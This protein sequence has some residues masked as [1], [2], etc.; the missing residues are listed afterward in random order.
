MD[1]KTDLPNLP[2]RLGSPDMDLRSDPRSDP[3]MLAA[4]APLGLDV[5]P[6]DPGV[7]SETPIEALLEYCAA[8]EVGF[9]AL[10]PM[11]TE[12]TPPVEGV[13]RRTEVIKGIDDND[14]N[15][16]IHQPVDMDGPLP[17]VVHTH[18]GGMVILQA[19]DVGYVRWRDELAATGLVVVGVEFRNG[20]GA[21][22]PHPFPAGLND[23]AAGVQWVNENRNDLGISK[24]VIS[25]E[26]GGGNL[27]L[28]TTLKAKQQGWVSVIDGVYAQCPYIFGGYAEKDP[29]LPSLYEND[30][31]FLNVTN[32]GA[33]ARVYDPSGENATNPLAWPYHA[34]VAELTGLPPHVISVNE[35]D[36]LRDEGLA[37]YRK[38]GLAGVPSVSR[39]VNGTCHA[40]DCLALD[41]MPD[42]Y[43]ATQRDI[44]GFANSL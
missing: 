39:T 32:M 13:V 26:S 21:L 17:C 42:V 35:L 33:L 34:D 6:E 37:Y 38:L 20:G 16:Y 1:T 23:C 19:S 2:G 28:A 41:A 44:N 22:G 7:T 36:P 40:G 3:R 10:G 25:G 29:A 12:A 9:A 43:R 30:D 18:G 31:Y 14:I 8:A 11:L 27:A 15:L 24:I 4:L 5:H